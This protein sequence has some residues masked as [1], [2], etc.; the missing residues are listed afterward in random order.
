MALGDDTFEMVES[1]LKW[2][3]DSKESVEKSLVVAHKKRGFKLIW[4][5]YV[6]LSDGRLFREDFHYA[7]NDVTRVVS[8]GEDVTSPRGRVPEGWVRTSLRTEGIEH[9]AAAWEQCSRIEDEATEQQRALRNWVVSE[10]FPKFLF[11]NE[12]RLRKDMAEWP[13]D[14][15]RNTNEFWVYLRE[16][17]FFLDYESLGDCASIYCAWSTELFAQIGIEKHYAY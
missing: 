11:D 15:P 3:T 10:A 13:A 7:G 4:N 12:Q 5:A 1:Y 6:R 16:L 9:L 8:A 17:G 2:V 14:R